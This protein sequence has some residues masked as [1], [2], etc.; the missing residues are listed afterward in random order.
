MSEKEQIRND[1]LARVVDADIMKKLT[2]LTK[3]SPCQSPALKYVSAAPFLPTVILAEVVQRLWE[4][5]SLLAQSNL[6]FKLTTIPCTRSSKTCGTWGP[7]LSGD[8]S[9]P[10]LASI[11]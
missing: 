3:V 9:L 8:L 7:H 1:F 6:K 5:M 11:C 2:V 10:L 4:R